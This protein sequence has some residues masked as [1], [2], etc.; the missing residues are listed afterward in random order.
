MLDVSSTRVTHC[1]VHRVGNRLREEGCEFSQKEVRGIEEL[2]GTLLRHY[3]TPFAKSGEDYEFYHE[4]DISLNAV[5]QFGSRILADAGSFLKVS[6]S[7]AK[8]L[9]S[10]STHPSI[11]EGEFIV[12]LFQD[13]RVDGVSHNALGFYKIEQREIFFDVEKSNDSMNL[14]EMNGIPV[15]NIQKGALI[16]GGDA[17]VFVKETGSQQTRYWVE[18]FLKARPRQN[19]KSTSKLA[20]EFVKQVC[21]RIDVE[22]GMSLRRD[23]VEIFSDNEN[24]NYKDVEEI[25]EK[26]LDRDEVSRL[27][28]QLEEKSGFSALS[29]S[30]LDSALLTRQAKNVL[31]H[32]PL[33]KDISL[34]IANSK[35]RLEKCSISKTKSG[36]RAIIDID[37]GE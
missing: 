25:S 22:A 21:S 26:Y 10:V 32:Y 5:M 20:A 24:I 15:S 27:T 8:H 29:E 36:Y 13:V 14:I 34:T 35:A 23:L 1:V 9:Y 37:L 30:T 19:K 28:Q 12:I 16:I 33:S 11:A 17:G 3:L 2:C 18:L 6:Q 4:S 31:H 7:I